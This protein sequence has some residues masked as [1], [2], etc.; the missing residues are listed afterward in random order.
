LTKFVKKFT[1]LIKLFGV[2]IMSEESVSR[3]VSFPDY[4]G[5]YIAEGNGEYWWEKKKEY[6]S[7]EKVYTHYRRRVKHYRQVFT[8][9][10]GLSDFCMAEMTAQKEIDC[11]LMRR[12]RGDIV[13]LPGEDV[14]DSVSLAGV[15]LSGGSEAAGE[16]LETFGEIQ[17][18]TEAEIVRWVFNHLEVKGLKPSDAPTPGAWA[19]LQFVRKSEENKTDFYK[20]TWPKTFRKEDMKGTGYND[21]GRATLDLIRQLQ[22]EVSG[23]KAV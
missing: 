21:D 11:L 17:D 13:S 18:V 14:E 8:D 9:W 22:Q 2:A 16:S 15:Q 1:F 6:Y 10:K 3:S 19:Y 5:K 7:F 4:I 12:A 20:T 23:D